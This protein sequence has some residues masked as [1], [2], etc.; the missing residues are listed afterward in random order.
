MLILSNPSPG[1]CKRLVSPVLQQISILAYWPSAPQEAAEQVCKLAHEVLKTFFKLFGNLRTIGP[2]IA[3]IHNKGSNS[4]A[5]RPWVLH[6]TPENRFAIVARPPGTPG[7]ELVWPDVVE[8]ISSLVED[9]QSVCSSSDLSGLFLNLLEKWVQKQSAH[10]AP[11]IT[12]RKQENNAES[13][14]TGLFEVTTLQKLMEKAPEKL[15]SQF[16][17]L[18]KLVCQ[19]LVTDERSRLEDEIL[20]VVLSLL[21]LVFGAPTFQKS[22][23]TADQLATVERSLVR[24]SAEDR[25]MVTPTAKNLQ[26]LLRYKNEIDEMEGREAGQATSVDTR[27]IED[28]RTYDLAMNYITGGD[29]PPPVVA[30]GLSLFSNLIV[31]G[32]PILDITSILVLSSNLLTN[33]DDYINL[34][35]IKIFTQVANKHPKTTITEILDHYLDVQEKVSTDVRLRFGE[36]L[37]Q[38]IQRLGETFTGDIAKQVG[39]TLLSIAGRRGYRP[40]TLRK[41][42]REARRKELKKKRE[43]GPNENLESNYT[44]DESTD[45]GA[46]NEDILAQIVQGW[47]SQRGSEDV[48]MRSSALSIF[49]TAMETNLSGLGASLASASI[50]LSVNVLTLEPELEK[51]ILRRA[52]IIVV[53][54]FV[55][56]LSA[57]REARRSLGFGLTEQSRSDIMVS[58]QYIAGT[59]NDELVRQHAA[60]VVESLENWSVTTM[61]PTQANLAPSGLTRLSG[62]ALGPDLGDASRR[63]RPRIEEI[64]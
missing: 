4:T 19:V 41:Q 21:N 25:P 54:S 40:K 23:L 62:L 49:A 60:D 24:L 42:Q 44:D 10:Q 56:A 20:A 31:A 14:L 64:E 47:E 51:A 3:N 39:E 15:V 2:I 5:V 45:E 43:Q 37:L 27:K 17:Q 55:S 35:V 9:I 13:D 48:R 26:M 34:Q 36:A 63:T 58:L 52:A 32:S 50:D 30:E 29:N 33:N 53:M 12:F 6:I 59:D 61:L 18:L 11:H 16:D 8:R 28:R 7:D 38:T 1:L 22:D 46:A 57:A